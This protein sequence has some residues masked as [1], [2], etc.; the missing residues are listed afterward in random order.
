MAYRNT[1]KDLWSVKALEGDLKGLV[2]AHVEQ[3]VMSGT[4][5][6]VSQ[7]GRERTVRTGRKTVHAGIVGQVEALWGAELRDGVDNKTIKGLGVAKPFL[8][9]DGVRV[10]YNPHE[11]KTFVRADTGAPV[12]GATRVLLDAKS[13]FAEGIT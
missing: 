10:R 8:P 6:E 7:A 11:T 12:K 2:V 9:L 4:S 3:L 5:F 13:V 1:H